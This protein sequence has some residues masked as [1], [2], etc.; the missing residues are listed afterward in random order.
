MADSAG[1]RCLL[2]CHTF[3]PL[4]GG[5]AGVY[6]ALA[7]HA[8]GAIAVLTSRLDPATGQ[9]RPGWRE[10]DAVA[11]HPVRRIGLVRPP[12]PGGALRNPVLRRAVWA[13]RA[14][15]LALA[16]AVEAR[17][18]RADAVCIC[19]DETVGWLVPFVRHGL[20][21]RALVYCHGDDLV[22]PDPAARAARRRWFDAAD[23]VIAA[24]G[25]P[26]AQLTGLYGVAREKVA[27]LA[28][29]VDL[30][31]FR[32]MPPDPAR[33]AALGL[34]GRR[35]ILAPTRLVPRKGVDRLIAAMPAI[36]ARHPDAILL[37]AGDGPQRVALE[38]MAAQSGGAEAVRFLGAVPAED[39]PA[40]YALAEFVALPNRAEPG[41]SDGTP[42]V[43]L[44]ANACGRPVIGGRAGGTPEA[45][46][47]G[48]NGLLVEGD[49]V[50]AIAAAVLR[51]LDDPALAARLARGGLEAAREAGWASR[52]DAFLALCR[53]C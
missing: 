38:A 26:A 49:D 13:M 8:R 45:V 17:R 24:G 36:R 41:E 37:V 20:R 25:F 14:L 43:F 10:A 15:R 51:L 33:R 52:T 42:L 30:D 28:N 50:A 40:L 1:P 2:V 23:R 11:G 6:A 19:D 27:V 47:D 16:V 35:V 7:R 39:M 44:E 31:R 46:Q 32:P 22:Q 4:I 53:A 9:E 34:D 18:H 5:S 21:R 29:G 3:P 12:L 48:R